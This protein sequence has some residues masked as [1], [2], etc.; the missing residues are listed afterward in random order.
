MP[1]RRLEIRPKISL[2]NLNNFKSVEIEVPLKIISSANKVRFC[3]PLVSLSGT[4]NGKDLQMKIMLWRMFSRQV[5]SDTNAFL[6]GLKTLHV[7]L[8][9]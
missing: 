5:M 7:F 8:I 6:N 1:A 2:L 3:N 4:T 9:H